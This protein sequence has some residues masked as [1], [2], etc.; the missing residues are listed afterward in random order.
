MMIGPIGKR[1]R[2]PSVP[3][4][5][6]LAATEWAR[7]LHDRAKQDQLAVSDM[8][9][10]WGLAPKSS[11]ALQTVAALLAYGLAQTGKKG[12]T[13]EVRISHLATHLF[14]E[15]APG[16]EAQQRIFTE[17]ALKPKLIAHYAAKWRGGRPDDDVCIGEF[18]TIHR[19]TRSG[20]ARFLQVFDEAMWFVGGGITGIRTDHDPED[21]AGL[22][23]KALLPASGV[24]IGDYVRCTDQFTAPCKVVW[25]LDGGRYLYVQGNL[26]RHN[27][28]EVRIVDPPPPP[29]RGDLVDE[30]A[31]P[32]PAFPILGFG[33]AIQCSRDLLE[34]AGR[35]WVSLGQAASVW[36]PKPERGAILRSLAGL[37]AFGLAEQSGSG[38]NE[39]RLRVSELGCRA[40]E[41]SCLDIRGPVWAEAASKPQLIADYAVRWRGSRPEDHVCIAQLVR[42][43]GLSEQMA[44][45][46]LRVFDEANFFIS[47]Y[48][49]EITSDDRPEPPPV[50]HS[51]QPASATGTSPPERDQFNVA[52]GS[53]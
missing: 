4:I 52:T 20:A 50:D 11:A 14:A 26:A 7:Q 3:F 15:P 30:T 36:Y 8:A 22:S 48:M 46:F 47:R 34:C 37:L 38:N 43:H 27:T 42:E 13:R 31:S 2:S 5:G 6:L 45:R 33:W 39:R 24:R 1:P 40:L 19:F 35:E 49:P 32:Q 41:D 9:G 23:G 18:T 44:A 17:A 51:R 53:K 10:I 21:E 12:G 16:L 29:F 28:A 25:L